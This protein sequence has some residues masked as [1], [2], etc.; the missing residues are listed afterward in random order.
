MSKHK[1]AD[2]NP[3]QVLWT[4]WASPRQMFSYQPLHKI[5]DYFGEKIAFYFSWL[6]FYTN[7][8]F[9]ASIAG[10]IVPIYGGITIAFDAP[11]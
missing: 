11:T 6:G 4:Y 2:L 9:I 10:L 1:I 5:R 3:R 7:W 8:L